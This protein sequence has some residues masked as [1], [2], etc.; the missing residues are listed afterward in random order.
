MI[1]I[2]L[3]G[4]FQRKVFHK[5]MYGGKQKYL[6]VCL[7]CYRIFWGSWCLLDWWITIAVTCSGYTRKT[8]TEH[9]GSI[10]SVYF[11][12]NQV[13]SE[14]TQTNLVL[15]CNFGYL[16]QSSFYTLWF[17]IYK[18]LQNVSKSLNFT[19]R[20]F[21]NYAFGTYFLILGLALQFFF[22][23]PF[24]NMS[25]IL[26]N[27]NPNPSSRISNPT[28]RLRIENLTFQ[29]ANSNCKSHDKDTT[30]VRNPT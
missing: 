5:R 18:L 4:Q 29:I 6:F 23:V 2:S 10:K 14:F 8:I 19:P 27:P 25:W 24:P 28:I 3:F 9:L 21:P 20:S 17:Y 12:S 30:R 15:E 11:G 1:K 13:P 26:H 7:A 16:V 22:T